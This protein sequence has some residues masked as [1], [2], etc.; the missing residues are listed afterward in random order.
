MAVGQDPG[1]SGD[2]TAGAPSAAPADPRGSLPVDGSPMPAW[3]DYGFLATLPVLVPD[4]DG[5]TVHPAVVHTSSCPVGSLQT[6]ASPLFT[7]RREAEEWLDVFG[8]DPGW[9][10]C[11]VC[12][13]EHKDPSGSVGLAD[14]LTA[15]REASPNSRIDYR[16]QIAAHGEAAIEAMR[17]WLTERSLAAFAVRVITAAAPS[18]EAEAVAMLSLA[19]TVAWGPAAGDAREALARLQGVQ[20]RWPR[21]PA[22]AR[23]C[24]FVG[25]GPWT[26]D[27][28]RSRLPAHSLDRSDMPAAFVDTVVVGRS[29]GQDA[30]LEALVRQLPRP[31]RFL[32]QEAWIALLLFDED[33]WLDEP[34]RLN[35]IVDGHPPLAAIRA[36][37]PTGFD[38]PGVESS[39]E[40]TGEPEELGS[41]SDL[42]RLGYN[43]SSVGRR[44][45]WSI[46]TEQAVPRLGLRPV[47]EFI[48]GLVKLRKLQAG[49][50]T[51][52]ARA[53]AEW[54]HDLAEL[55]V[56]LYRPGT[57]RFP[58]PGTEP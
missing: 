3:S 23:A 57:S 47:A 9:A 55:K 38:W 33:W 18:A 58:W 25:D 35:R 26:A 24:A 19:S 14:L 22:E 32:P 28:L 43:V 2:A 31:A 53:I 49:G 51:R 50:R 30:H 29:A 7:T 1:A 20:P 42:M 17:S 36:G 10:T 11:P 27:E 21:L 54:E 8:D 37:W 44:E 5:F 12:L 4:R 6:G 16:D 52:Y 34:D 56:H 45:R 39:G 15:A 48:A 46:L 13:P 40:G 41:E